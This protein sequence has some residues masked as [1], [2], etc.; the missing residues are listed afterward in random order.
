MRGYGLGSAGESI[1]L[2][3][4]SM[5]LI[6]FLSLANVQLIVRMN[7]SGQ[8]ANQKVTLGIVRSN[9]TSYLNND[10]AWENTLQDPGNTSP[11][12]QCLRDASVDCEPYVDTDNYLRIVKNTADEVVYDFSGPNNGFDV[13]GA[14]CDQ[15]PTGNGENH[16]T[17]CR[18]R[19]EITW[20]PTCGTGP[21]LDPS[22]VITGT[23]VE[24]RFG[25][26]RVPLNLSKYNF[27]I[28]R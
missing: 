26:N 19:Y 11:S 7:K 3:V 17:M 12:V 2:L 4:I 1:P 27:R 24:K 5:G 25:Q 22:M 21:C 20:E 28:V 15:Y 14:P 13:N 8:V 9:I 18:F 10:E 23:L 16:P 6:G